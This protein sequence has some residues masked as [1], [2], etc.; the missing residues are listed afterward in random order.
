LQN[1]P[2]I[3]D[4]GQHNIGQISN[5]AVNIIQDKS[6]VPVNII[7]DKLDAGVMAAITKGPGFDFVCN[8]DEQIY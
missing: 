6:T 7:Q 2:Q 8:S 1:S 5:I 4:S 3:N